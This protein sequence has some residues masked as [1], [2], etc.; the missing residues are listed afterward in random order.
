MI[1]IETRQKTFFAN[2][3]TT[4][5]AWHYRGTN[6]VCVVMAGGAGVTKEPATDLFAERFND[7]G[8]SVLAFDFRRLGESGGEPRQ[9]VR[10]RDQITDFEAAVAFARTLPEV[11]PAKVALWGFSL[12]GGH[13]IRVA[14]RNS[15]VAAVIAQV[16]LADARA[17]AP[18]ALRSMTAS[19]F[20]RLTGRGLLDAI[21]GLFGRRPLLVPLSGAR[22]DVATITTP[23]SAD[24]DRAL[25]PGNRYPDWLRA[26]AA[27]STLA[28][29]FYRPG[30]DAP[31]VQ[32]PLLVVVSDDDRTV[33]PEPGIRVA[34]RAPR[35]EVVR[36]PGNHYASL[37]EAHEEAVEAELE[38]LGR[39]LVR[40]G[41]V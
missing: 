10:I 19:A 40:S 16:P 9:V 30:L 18:N 31:R 1:S 4:L 2:D 32:C 23:D 22:G 33:L 12:S 39:H 24:A 5:A 34:E 11:D 7:A 6:G 35:G 17:A 28:T 14:A 29:G 27:R 20:L 25:N 36:L 26:V 13:A 15:D 21:G 37:L 3:D 38:F 41:A 8:H